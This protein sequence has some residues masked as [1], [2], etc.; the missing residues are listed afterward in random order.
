MSMA[1]SQLPSETPRLQVVMGVTGCGK[2]TIGR[3]WAQAIGASCIEGDDH[4]PPA[5]IEKMSRGEPLDDD[6]RWPWLRVFARTLSARP[7]RVVGSC[8]SLKR[9]YREAIVDAAGEPVVFIYL[10]GSPELIAGR[11]AMRK[12]HFMD[13][14]LLDSQFDALETPLDSEP[15]ITVDIDNGVSGIVG[16]IERAIRSRYR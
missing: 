4:H 16:D 2:S 7:G 3:A 1:V 5:N 11:L 15:V 10:N 8:S 14:G 13:P 6:D 12:G 9:S